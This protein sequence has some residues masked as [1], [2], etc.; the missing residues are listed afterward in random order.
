MKIKPIK[1]RLKRKTFVIKAYGLTITYD[2][3]AW[4]E[5]DLKRF[6]LKKV[7]EGASLEECF[8]EEIKKD[9]L[10]IEREEI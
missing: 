9:M 6:M 2:P 4:L 8:A 1:D 7:E 5:Y 10:C 3:V